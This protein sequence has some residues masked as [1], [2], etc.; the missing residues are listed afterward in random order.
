MQVHIEAKKRALVHWA[1]ARWLLSTSMFR[2][3]IGV[4]MPCQEMGSRYDIASSEAGP[5]G[6]RLWLSYGVMHAGHVPL[7]SFLEAI[8]TQGQ[9]IPGNGEHKIVS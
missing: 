4:P 3:G 1:A 2:K 9:Y 7:R 5:L 8:D 6:V